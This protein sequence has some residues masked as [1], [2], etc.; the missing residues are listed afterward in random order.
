MFQL[1]E[2][3]NGRVLWANNLL[4]FCLSLVPFATNWMGETDFG[5]MPTV[6]YGIVL[7]LPGAAYYFLTRAL[8]RLHGPD[9]RLARAV[10][11]GTKEWLSLVIYAV[12]I[13]AAFISP[14]LGFAFYCVVAAM[15]FIPDRRMER[16]LAKGE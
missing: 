7:S 15:W 6:V 5:L 3:V 2:R 8:I 1:V 16:A 4:L 12:G 10:G 9:S 11:S 14:Y 13:G